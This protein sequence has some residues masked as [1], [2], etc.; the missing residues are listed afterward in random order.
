MADLAADRND[1]RNAW[2]RQQARPEYEV[3]IFASGHGAGHFGIDGQRD[4]HDLAHDRRYG[5][6][7][8]R[9]SAGKLFPDQCEPLGYQ[10]PVAV[11][12]AAPVKLGVDDG[13]ANA[14]NGPHAG[15]ARHA[16]QRR[17]D[18]ERCEQFHFLGSHTASFRDHRDKWFVE[19]R[20]HVHGGAPGREGAV[21]HQDGSQ[22]QHQQPVAEA[23][24]NNP[25]EHGAPLSDLVDQ[26][27][28]CDDHPVLRRQ[29][30]GD[31]HGARIERADFNELRNKA[32]RPGLDPDDWLV[33]RV[34]YQCLAG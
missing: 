13:Q 15:H 31:D 7:D 8:R 20:K 33:V 3:R 26:R 18:G 21:H 5:A 11:D 17:L 14:R 28:A 4:Q 10:L 29:S 30:P 32:L 25:V 27:G 12:V 16:I 2:Y 9:Q 24:A 23:R 19:I 22:G 34:P 6:E 1:L